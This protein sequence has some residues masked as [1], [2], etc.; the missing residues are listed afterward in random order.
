MEWIFV[1]NKTLINLDKCHRIQLA[2]KKIIFVGGENWFES[3]YDNEFIAYENFKFLSEYLN[4][5]Q[6]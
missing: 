4:I 6:K 2:E 1:N 3:N 5:E